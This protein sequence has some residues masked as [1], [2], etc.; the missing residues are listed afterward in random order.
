MKF[1]REVNLKCLIGQFQRGLKIISGSSL[2][3]SVAALLGIAGG[4]VLA[5]KG[6]KIGILNT[7]HL[8]WLP[9][10][11]TSSPK[12]LPLVPGL[13]NLGNNCFLNVI[14]QALAS[15]SYFQPF[16][17]NVLEEYEFSAFQDRV[18]GFP[19]TIALAALLEDLS[20]VGGGRVVLSPRKLMLVMEAY[21]QNFDLT[22][23][24]DAA[25]A[26]L[27]LLSSLREEFSDCYL[28][29]QCSLA[30]LLA[31]NCRIIT[32][33]RME[34]QSEQARWQQHYLGPFDGI[35]GSIL[36]CRSC[37]T[38]IS[39][40]FES[41]HSLP[42][43]PVLNGGA[44]IMV[45]CTL[46]N[47]LEQFTAAEQVENYHCNHC[48][49]IAAVKYLFSMGV[50]E[51][52]IEKI[53]RCPEQDSCDCQR[54]IHLHKLPWSNKF[55]Y[56]LKQISIAR[57]PKILCVHLKRVSINMFGELVKL[58]GHISFPLVLDLL[59]FTTS[60]VGI[61]SLEENMKK[62]EVQ[63]QNRNSRTFPNQFNMQYDQIKLNHI[64]GLTRGSIYPE[65]SA[66]D[67]S[68]FTANAKDVPAESRFS[69]AAGF[70]KTMQADM[71]MHS[72]DQLTESCKV[73]PSSTCL[74][75]L[76]AIVEHFGRAGSGH[77]TVYRSVRA[78]LCEEPCDESEVDAAAWCWYSV[79]DSEVCRVSEEDVLAAEASF[80]FFEKYEG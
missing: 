13:Q 54:H 33:T 67:V 45:G 61:K 21:I 23:Q 74:Y 46:E 62:G 2:I 80:L 5:L 16:L 31:S 8:E 19:L 17:Q 76:V 48:W 75:R 53:K 42:L 39:L 7:L 14:L 22:S 51:E 63:R 77:Y 38:Q 11:Q 32:P 78:D 70:S 65:E 69:E 4:F 55:S 28:P 35:L 72:E 25:E 9:N 29:N 52:E 58:Q 49:H 40:N 43:S 50:N 73:V 34:N 36:M 41:F 24:Q 37:S 47:C 57:C 59:R 20:V 3:S 71:N 68:Q 10:T 26:F 44:T 27:H 18:D 6:S 60:D 1:E 30:E 79:S 66:S 15:C 56:T 12:Q 64:Y